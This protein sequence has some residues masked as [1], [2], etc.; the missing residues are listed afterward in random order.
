MKKYI[1]LL[2]IVLLVGCQDLAVTNNNE[3][4]RQQALAQPADL[5]SLLEGSSATALVTGLNGF[6]GIYP[7]LLADQSSTTNAYAGFWD[8]AEQPRLRLQNS[9]S[10]PDI[11][12]I[13]NPWSYWNRSISTANTL[14]TIIES[15]GQSIVVDGED[16]TESVHAAAYFL[17]G[18]S[19]G[20]ISL[21][22]DKGY[23]VGI[24][25][26]VASIQ[27]T[28][29]ES[30]NNAAI[31][32]F[33]QAIQIAQNASS[34]FSYSAVTGNQNT[35]SKNEFIDIVN[36]FAAKVLASMPRTFDEANNSSHW[37]R[38]QQY[39]DKGLGGPNSLSSLNNFVFETIAS[40]TLPYNFADWR[41][42]VLSTNAGYLP[43]DQKIAHLLDPNNQPADYPTADGVILPPVQSEDPRA[44]YFYYTEDFGYLRASR[45]RAL[46]TNHWNFRMWAGNNW[47]EGGYPIPVLTLSEMIYIRAEAAIFQGNMAVAADL[48]NNSPAGNSPLNFEYDLP[49]VQLGY[50]TNESAHLSGGQVFDGTESLSDLQ[51]TLLKEYSIELDLMG[52]FGNHWFMM[53][54]HDLLQ[55]GTPLHYPVPA[56]ELEITGSEVYSFGGA[57]YT[58]EIGTA[59]GSNS[60]KNLYAKTSYSKVRNASLSYSPL[61]SNNPTKLNTKENQRING[62]VE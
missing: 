7:D 15:D 58:S 57:G 3:P 14:L 40:G 42:F 49:S 2:P 45:N 52:G 9:T 48:L 22:Y 19:S 56:G 53:R 60:W 10:N 5:V 36:S 37:Q 25:D 26:N 39:A 4:D 34:N 18:M 16:I 50:F 54:R 47:W 30:V 38:V 31:A 41:G 13:A 62:K 20:Y 17:R 33:D 35:W 24:N 11:G 44:S 51:W 43:N 6:Y 28:D 29:Y 46:F 12:V 55:E 59:D 1:Y 61:V 8:Y 32:D 27:L 23:V 21:T